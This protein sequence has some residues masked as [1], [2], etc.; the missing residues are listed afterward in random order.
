M[1]EYVSRRG[2]SQPDSNFEDLKDR[3]LNS[4]GTGHK[5]LDF[6]MFLITLIASTWVLQG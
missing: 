1:R 5:I 4:Q 6:E 2:V 3:A